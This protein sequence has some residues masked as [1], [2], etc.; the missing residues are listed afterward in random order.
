MTLKVMII[1]LHK[2]HMQTVQP[3]IANKVLLMCY[4]YTVINLS[5]INPQVSIYIHFI[6]P[7]LHF[8][9]FIFKIRGTLNLTTLF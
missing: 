2:I 3:E 4:C 7:L 9:N 5:T 8:N 6:G 1:D